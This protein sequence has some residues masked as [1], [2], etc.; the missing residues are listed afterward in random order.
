M[1]ENK[2]LHNIETLNK[3][4]QDEELY[5]LSAINSI[6]PMV[7]AEYLM[8]LQELRRLGIA[9]SGNKSSDK[10]KLEQAKAELINKIKDKEN[11]NSFANLKVQTIQPVN[12]EEEAK[13]AEMEIKKLGAMNIAELNRLYFNI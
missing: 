8:I 3:N 11:E 10:A 6:N 12:Q 9:P 1:F 5:L 2:E 4:L 7:D 13:R